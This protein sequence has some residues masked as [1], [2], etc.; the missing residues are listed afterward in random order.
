MGPGQRCRRCQL[1]SARSRDG[2]LLRP[3]RAVLVGQA[4]PADHAAP[5]RLEAR[6]AL[7]AFLDVL[8]LREALGQARRREL[9]GDALKR[10]RTPLP[11]L[12]ALFEEGQAQTPPPGAT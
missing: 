1:C 5:L 12:A 9:F 11:K 6:V 7:V 8:S 2:R 3:G 10:L 4:A